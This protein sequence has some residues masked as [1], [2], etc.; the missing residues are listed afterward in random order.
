MAKKQVKAKDLKQAKLHKVEFDKV[1][2]LTFDFNAL[3]ELQELGYEN[4]YYAIAGFERMHLKSLKDL[5]YAALVAGQLAEDEDVEFDLS[6]NKVGRILGQLINFENPKFVKI[7][8]TLG[9]AVVDF[10]PEPEVKEDGIEEDGEK[11]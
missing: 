2:P 11:K 3:C 7:S 9:M 6:I 5:V 4:P 8:E 1:R 10:F